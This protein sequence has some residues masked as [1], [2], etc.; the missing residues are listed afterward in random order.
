MKNNVTVNEFL[1]RFNS[2]WNVVD[3]L[4][5]SQII[6]VLETG[7]RKLQA[8]SFR[9]LLDCDTSYMTDDYLVSTMRLVAACGNKKSIVL[10][11]LASGNEEFE[12]LSDAFYSIQ[13]LNKKYRELEED[14]QVQNQIAEK[15]KVVGLIGE[16]NEKIKNYFVANKMAY[17][18][19]FVSTDLRKGLTQIKANLE[20]KN[21][22]LN[23]Q[24][25]TCKQAK[26]NKTYYNTV[27]TVRDFQN[28]L[29]GN[30]DGKMALIAYKRDSDKRRLFESKSKYQTRMNGSINTIFEEI[31]IELNQRQN[32]LNS[33]LE[34]INKREVLASLIGVDTTVYTMSQLDNVLTKYKDDIDITQE[35]LR[36]YSN[37]RCS[38][39]EQIK[40]T[41]KEVG[42]D[43]RYAMQNMVV[44]N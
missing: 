21:E 2:F 44:L 34:M 27:K 1:K 41:A 14:E 25:A 31:Q 26:S 7:D 15:H 13:R 12:K 17:S 5:R 32:K 6:D 38:L 33:V 36:S 37:Q 8:E 11:H 18:D 24:I 19:Q 35:L 29:L 40:T 3:K 43:Y 16:L 9:K 10:G 30:V 20:G 23:W 4:K 22:I 42:L 28:N 39:L